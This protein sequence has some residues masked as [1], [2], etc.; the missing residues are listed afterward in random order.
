MT[1]TATRMF[2]NARRNFATNGAVW[3]ERTEA[4]VRS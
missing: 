4:A 1:D 2:E 3:D